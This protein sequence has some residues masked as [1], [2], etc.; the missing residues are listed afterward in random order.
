M[1]RPRGSGRGRG[2]P[3]G[4][5]KRVKELMLYGDPSFDG[6]DFHAPDAL[7]YDVNP[8]SGNNTPCEDDTPGINAA[9]SL[10]HAMEYRALTVREYK[11]F[12]QF[13]GSDVWAF[14]IK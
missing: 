5:I 4:S 6:P 1:G 3:P 7:G 8:Y 14:F 10:A 2:R 11:V 9:I 12:H 13:L